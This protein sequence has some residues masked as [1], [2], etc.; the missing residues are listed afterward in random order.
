MTLLNFILIGVGLSSAIL[1]CVWFIYNDLSA[2]VIA[3]LMAA[4]I[5]FIMLDLFNSFSR[6]ETE[7]ITDFD[8]F[9]TNNQVIVETKND[10]FSFTDIKTYVNSDSISN[11]NIIHLYSIYRYEKKERRRVELMFKKPD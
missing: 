6:T 9:K 5:W 7:I 10:N 11:I 8:V 1:G 2:S 4:F 3:A